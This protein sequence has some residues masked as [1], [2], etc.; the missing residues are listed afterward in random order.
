MIGCI[1]TNTL[2]PGRSGAL[3][4]F[5]PGQ[6][7]DNVMF[8][9]E[10]VLTKLP[11]PLWRQAGARA[12]ALGVQAPMRMGLERASSGVTVVGPLRLNREVRPEDPRIASE[13]TGHHG[14]LRARAR[15]LPL[16]GRSP[17]PLSHL[18][19]PHAFLPE[20]EDVKGRRMLVAR[21][22]ARRW[23]RLLMTAPAIL[24][25]CCAAPSADRVGSRHSG[26]QSADR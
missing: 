3:H 13:P 7:R 19:L 24:R 20:R 25:I 22:F 4:A 18:L 11:A 15:E 14:F 17:Y 9:L 10:H 26:H 5:A 6:A 2:G 23:I 16:S 1:L 8:E 21:S 12:R